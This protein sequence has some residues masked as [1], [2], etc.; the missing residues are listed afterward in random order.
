MLLLNEIYREVTA[1]STQLK[2]EWP[3]NVLRHSFISYRLPI[4]KSAEQV[5][6][7]PRIL[8]HSL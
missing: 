6:A 4:V 8:I 7:C 1:L 3:R 2:I 5:V